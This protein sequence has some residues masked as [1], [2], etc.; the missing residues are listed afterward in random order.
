MILWRISNYADL[1]GRGGLVSSGRW[2][3]RGRPVVYLAES[4]AGALIEALVHLELNEA[5]LP[6]EY[7]LLKV[8]I[9]SSVRAEKTSL[10]ALGEHWTVNLAVSRRL[11]DEWLQRRSSP[12]LRVPSVVVPETWNWVLNP[13]HP[14]ARRMRIVWARHYEWDVRLR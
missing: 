12:L 11:G 5:D 13:A 7:Q 10:S 8:S 1:E 2:H 4:S 9:P 14:Q 6:S 3:T